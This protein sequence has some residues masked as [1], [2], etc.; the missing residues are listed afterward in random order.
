M[1]GVIG[2]IQRPKQFAMFRGQAYMNLTF[3]SIEIDSRLIPVQMSLL[4]VGEPRINSDS[5]RRRDVKIVEGE[6][7]E[8]KHDYKGDALGMAIGGGGGSAVGLV[9]SN[10]ARGFGIGFAAGAIYVVARKGKEVEMPA[11]TGIWRGWTARLRC[12][13]QRRATTPSAARR[14]PDRTRKNP[15]RARPL[16]ALRAGVFVRDAKACGEAP[17]WFGKDRAS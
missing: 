5:K 1:H 4:A 7:V 10:V 16:V 11:Q 2:T 9:F 6:V 3:K 13:S 14:I 8:Q 15:P 17:A 12:R